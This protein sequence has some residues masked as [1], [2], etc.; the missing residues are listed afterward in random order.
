MSGSGRVDLPSNFA[1]KGL[2]PLQ[3]L[4]HHRRGGTFGE[5]D[6]VF[7]GSNHELNKAAFYQNMQQQTD[8]ASANR[9]AAQQASMPAQQN[10]YIQQAAPVYAAP[11]NQGLAGVGDAGMGYGGD[12]GGY[13]GDGGAGGGGSK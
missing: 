2:Q 5:S 10:P 3:M 13:G 1:A 12:N 11:P 6:D 7:D 4:Q 9:L 8:A